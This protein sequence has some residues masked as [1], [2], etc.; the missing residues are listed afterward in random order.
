LLIQKDTN[1]DLIKLIEYLHKNKPQLDLETLVFLSNDT[2]RPILF[3]YYQSMNNVKY[4]LE[5]EDKN[6]NKIENK[7]QEKPVITK[8]VVRKVLKKVNSKSDNE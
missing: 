3:D 6:E 5:I 2:N 4:D 8:K 1:Y 7:I